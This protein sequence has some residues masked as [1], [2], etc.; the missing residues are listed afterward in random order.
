MT[1]RQ[2]LAVCLAAALV[3]SGCGGSPVA[4]VMATAQQMIGGRKAAA[5]RPSQP[6]DAE[7]AAS[8]QPLLRAKVAGRG[9]DTT[10]TLRERDGGIATWTTRGGTTFT[11]RNGVLIETRGLGSDLMSSA[12][13]S[14][15]QL[16]RTGT[17]YR[18]AYFVTG[19]DNGIEERL[20]TCTT[21]SLGPE[22]L[23]IAGRTL[24][25]LHLRETCLRDAGKLTSDYWLEGP[26]VRK[27][28]QWAS[29]GAGYAEFEVVKD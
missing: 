8:D 20:Y 4:T 17:A 10:L 2:A 28:R 24:G 23:V 9:L 11:F 3:L 13:P 19:P 26:V 15:A 7:I 6:T 27:S 5:A 21:E 25:A 14:P 22:S 29:P 12:A 18:R 1:Q 16:T